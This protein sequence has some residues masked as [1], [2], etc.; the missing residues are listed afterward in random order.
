MLAAS[1]TL[2]F[3]SVAAHRSVRFMRHDS[4]L[5]VIGRIFGGGRVALDPSALNEL[6]CSHVPWSQLRASRIAGY[7]KC[8]VAWGVKLK[9]RL[10]LP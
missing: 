6:I 2:P 1:R 9:G 5:K 7:S 4:L 8:C 10:K 3:A